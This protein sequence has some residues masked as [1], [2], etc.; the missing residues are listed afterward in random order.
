MDEQGTIE[1]NKLKDNLM[2]DLIEYTKLKLV[3]YLKDKWNL[4]LTF[5]SENLERE[6]ID[7]NSI[8]N[9]SSDELFPPV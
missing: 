9:I 8:W 1:I 3:N 2:K 6:I 4:E 5:K 7:L